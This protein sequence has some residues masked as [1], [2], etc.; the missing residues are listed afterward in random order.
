MSMTDTTE[1]TH[2]KLGGLLAEL[3]DLNEAR[4]RRLLDALL[5]GQAGRGL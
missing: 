1:M 2:G 3:A 5:R 4:L